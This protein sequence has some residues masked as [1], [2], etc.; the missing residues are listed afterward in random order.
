MNLFLDPDRRADIKADLGSLTRVHRVA[1]VHY[2][3]YPADES[4]PRCGHCNQL[5]HVHLWQLHDPD[6]FEQGGII[7]CEVAQ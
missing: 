5:L 3:Y 4:G 7:D 6:L 2:G 1:D